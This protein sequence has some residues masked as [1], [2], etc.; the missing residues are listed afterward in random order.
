MQRR[1]FLLLTVFSL[2]A[3]SLRRAWSEDIPTD[4]G[5]KV[6]VRIDLP[7]E[8]LENERKLAGSD[9]V[10]GEPKAIPPYP[11]AM[12]G[13]FVDPVTVIVVISVVFLAERLIHYVLSKNGEGA[14][15]D[16]REKP[17]HISVLHG[18]P[19]GFV[20]MIRADGTPE[21]I[22]ADIPPNELAKVLSGV[23]KTATP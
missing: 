2:A 3:S 10:I 9:Y 20:I 15:I 4:K 11:D 8:L 7:R 19:Q 23:L 18:V 5:T 13:R 21:T 1:R 16:A 12:E 22:R 6:E 14:V 17:P